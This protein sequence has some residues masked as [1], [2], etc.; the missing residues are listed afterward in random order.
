MALLNVIEVL[1]TCL[2]TKQLLPCSPRVVCY[3]ETLLDLMCIENSPYGNNTRVTKI[4]PYHYVEIFCSVLAI[5]SKEKAM[6]V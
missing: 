1:A 3:Q 2:H 5:H 6:G 4:C